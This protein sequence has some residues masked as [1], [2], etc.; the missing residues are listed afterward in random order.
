[1]Y[2][3]TF[4]FAF[5]NDSPYLNVFLT[6]SVAYDLQNGA[7]CSALNCRSGYRGEEFAK[8]GVDGRTWVEPPGKICFHISQEARE[9]SKVVALRLQECGWNPDNFGVCEL[10][11]NSQNFETSLAMRTETQRQSI[12]D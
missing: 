9:T 8:R 7:K 5:K 3:R 12:I 6:P 1:M 11:F 2:A 10:H 4:Y